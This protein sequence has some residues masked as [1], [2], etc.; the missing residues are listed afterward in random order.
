MSS[1]RLSQFWRWFTA[2]AMPWLKRSNGRRQCLIC[3]QK[4]RP[5]PYGWRVIGR[6]EWR[7]C[8]C[9]QSALPRAGIKEQS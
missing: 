1:M 9:H 7:Q 6:I 8:K 3:G 4:H 5:V 2:P